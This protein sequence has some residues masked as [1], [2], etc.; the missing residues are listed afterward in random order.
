[1]QPIANGQPKLFSA[2]FNKPCTHLEFQCSYGSFLNIDRSATSLVQSD[3]QYNSY[4]SLQIILPPSIRNAQN[5]DI[6]MLN[7]TNYTGIQD[8]IWVVT[9]VERQESNNNIQSINV[10]GEKVN[11]GLDPY[12]LPNPWL[13]Q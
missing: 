4:D 1:M 6:F 12:S 10:T 9:A 7:D 3:R 11:L 13:Y 2:V 5:G 8:T